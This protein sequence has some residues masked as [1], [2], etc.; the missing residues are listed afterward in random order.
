MVWF[1][2]DVDP[3][4]RL[5]V[6]LGRCCHVCWLRG[7]VRFV[8]MCMCVYVSV[9]FYRYRYVPYLREWPESW[10]NLPEK[11]S[12]G[13]G[14]HYGTGVRAYRTGSST[15]DVRTRTAVECESWEHPP[16]IWRDGNS[17][18]VYV[19]PV[20]WVHKTIETATEA[21]LCLYIIIYTVRA[22]SSFISQRMCLGVA[23]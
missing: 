10:P 14:E 5:I 11:I 4:A 19:N 21:N 16:T 9:C 12:C 13:T 3:N 18:I 20:L 23:K 8:E 15:K 7:P 2:H 22:I 6:C 1:P 17:K